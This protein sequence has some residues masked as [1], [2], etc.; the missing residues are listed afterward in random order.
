[1]IS[2]Q[3]LFWKYEKGGGNKYE[4][5]YHFQ[6]LEKTVDFKQ[7]YGKNKKM[8][9]NLLEYYNSFFIAIIS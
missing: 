5:F 9:A 8:A 1:M 4:L 6:E 3:L 7:I 2:I